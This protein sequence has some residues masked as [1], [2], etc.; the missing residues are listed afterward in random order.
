M[1]EPFITTAVFIVSV[2]L[3]LAVAGGV[4]DIMLRLMTL[5]RP[6][7]RVSAPSDASAASL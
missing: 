5:W 4:L 2:L 6:S 1:I 3:A 7:N